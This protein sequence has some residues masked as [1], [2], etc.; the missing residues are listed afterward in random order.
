MRGWPTR[1]HQLQCLPSENRSF[2]KFKKKT[3][4]PPFHPLLCSEA[5]K[6]PVQPKHSQPPL[7]CPI[8]T[9]PNGTH[10]RNMWVSKTARNKA[11]PKELD[12]DRGCAC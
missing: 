5:K 7:M 12:I 3:S 8:T 4:T 11:T 9:E 6:P 10:N 1:T 2:K